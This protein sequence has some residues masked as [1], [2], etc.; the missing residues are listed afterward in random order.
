MIPNT[1]EIVTF[2]HCRLCTDELEA[3]EIELS[4]RDYAELEVGFTEIGLQIWCRR[5]ECNIT[6]V[7]Y[8]GYQ[9]PANNDRIEHPKLKV[10][11]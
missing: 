3:G 8:E 2:L 10:V 9:H 11:K 7:D 5:H 4:P 6:H 1:N